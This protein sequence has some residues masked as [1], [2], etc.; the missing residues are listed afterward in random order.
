MSY[1]ST[2]QKQR[3]PP[4]K[5]LMSKLLVMFFSEGT[6]LPNVPGGKEA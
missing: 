1:V 5:L 3:G 2:Q 6:I 4:T